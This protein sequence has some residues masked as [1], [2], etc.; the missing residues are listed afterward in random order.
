MTKITF[1]ICLTII[2]LGWLIVISVDN[3]PPLLRCMSQCNMVGNI[4]VNSCIRM[5]NEKCSVER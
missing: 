4:D 2:L 5:C 3:K 1:I